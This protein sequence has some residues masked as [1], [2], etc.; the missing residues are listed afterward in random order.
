MKYCFRVRK[1][2]TGFTAVEAV[3]SSLFVIVAVIFS[4]DCW[5]MVT[6]ARVTDS[7]CKDAARAA[8]QTVDTGNVSVDSTNATNAA[9]AAV[10]PY[11]QY[12]N[13]MMTAPMVSVAYNST[14][15]PP[16]VTVVTTMSV[17]P[18]VPLT[19]LGNTLGGVNFSQQYSFP[20]IKSMVGV[21]ISGQ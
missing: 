19:V 6:A 14:A 9:Q 20:L 15:N 1:R 12:A 4:L 5:F 7:A 16:N 10:Q 17:T 3:V 2:R 11:A 21:G 8:A 18:L 13:S